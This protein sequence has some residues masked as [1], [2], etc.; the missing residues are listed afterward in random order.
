MNPIS[1]YTSASFTAAIFMSPIDLRTFEFV[2]K[3]IIPI[4]FIFLRRKLFFIC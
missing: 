4:A 3:A 2:L 1:K